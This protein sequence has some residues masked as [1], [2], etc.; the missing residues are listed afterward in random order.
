MSLFTQRVYV[1][2]SKTLSDMTNN[3]FIEYLKNLYTAPLIKSLSF[4]NSSFFSGHRVFS[5]R[6]LRTSVHR[7]G[8]AARVATMNRKPVKFAAFLGREKLT[9]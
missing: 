5:A 9:S 1:M 7:N 4:A 6:Q 2:Q 8:S 3:V